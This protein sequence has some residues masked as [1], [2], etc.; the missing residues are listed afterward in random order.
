MLNQASQKLELLFKQL[1]PV[2]DILEVRLRV[3]STGTFKSLLLHLCL[4]HMHF[5]VR[6]TCRGPS[7]CLA[8]ARLESGIGNINC[9]HATHAYTAT[10]CKHDAS[11]FGLVKSQSIGTAFK[12]T[13]GFRLKV[14]SKPAPT[15]ICI[16]TCT[17]HFSAN[18]ASSKWGF[19]HAWPA[20]SQAPISR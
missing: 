1:R 7:A 17:K 14:T 19:C 12:S 3:P 18:L 13:T 8:T 9:M 15:S 10:C 2:T 20:S 6:K 16:I 11:A 4:L 5:Q